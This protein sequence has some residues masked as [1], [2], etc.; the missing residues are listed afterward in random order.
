M[1]KFFIFQK[2][3]YRVK[4]IFP[5]VDSTNQDGWVKDILAKRKRLLPV[6]AV[7]VQILGK[8]PMR[9]AN[10]WYTHLSKNARCRLYL[11]PNNKVAGFAEYMQKIIQP[12]TNYQA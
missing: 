10:F 2:Q 1:K 6:T 3:G 7:N 12:L 5:Q 4:N 8:D 11:P 9:D